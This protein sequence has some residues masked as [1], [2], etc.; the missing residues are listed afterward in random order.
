MKKLTFLLIALWVAA[1]V[2]APLAP[3]FA[4]G[5]TH[6]LKGEVV[7]VD[8]AANKITFKDEKGTS[9]TS[10][11]KDKAVE[12]LK[13]LKA[14]DKVVLTCQDD[15]NGQHQAIVAIRVLPPATGE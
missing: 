12:T 6:D 3:A 13:T 8:A 11:V 14:G 10:P 9:Q 15:E 2:L 1:S 4:A 7:S 5:K